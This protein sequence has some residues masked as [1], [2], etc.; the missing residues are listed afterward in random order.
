MEVGHLLV[1]WREPPVDQRA[2]MLARWGGYYRP[3][4]VETVVGPSG[5]GLEQQ[6]VQENLL[7]AHYIEIGFISGAVV[8]VFGVGDVTGQS[9]KLIWLRT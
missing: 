6:G 8:P 7:S 4:C 2:R 3:V 5:W 1:E 9:K